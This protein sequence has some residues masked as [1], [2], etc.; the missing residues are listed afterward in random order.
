MGFTSISRCGILECSCTLIRR[1]QL[2]TVMLSSRSTL[3]LSFN[4]DICLL[5]VRRLSCSWHVWY[6]DSGLVVLNTCSALHIGIGKSRLAASPNVYV[7]FPCH[8]RDLSLEG[9]GGCTSRISQPRDGASSA[10]TNSLSNFLLECG[11]LGS[12]LGFLYLS[13]VMILEYGRFYRQILVAANFIINNLSDGLSVILPQDILI[14]LI[15]GS[16]FL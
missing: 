6:R 2:P 14:Q 10:S 15:L 13:L 7:G 16:C 4:S 3:K 5:V 11:V 12:L 9:G 8:S 1:L